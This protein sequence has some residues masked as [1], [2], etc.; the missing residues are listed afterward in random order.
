MNIGKLGSDAFWRQLESNPMNLAR[1]VAEIDL[2]DL[3]TTLQQHPALRAWVNAAYETARIEEE[4]AKWELGK[5]KADIL[6]RAKAESDPDTGKAK[7]VGVIDAEVN[8]DP[9]VQ[10]FE[11][12]LMAVSQKRGVLQAISRA[13][14]DRKDM[15][16]QIAAKH[17][18]ESSDYH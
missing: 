11:D 6:L 9:S 7:T 4:R 16:I 8:A 2:I 15:L 18:Q 3:E 5:V 13:L 1:E 14:E 12:A 10:E 17:R